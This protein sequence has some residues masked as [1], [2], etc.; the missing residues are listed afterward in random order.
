MTCRWQSRKVLSTEPWLLHASMNFATSKGG[1]DE[2]IHCLCS[3]N[4]V[5]HSKV[6]DCRMQ[7]FFK[8]LKIYQNK[9]L[10]LRQNSEQYLVWIKICATHKYRHI[11]PNQPTLDS[12]VMLLTLD[13]WAFVNRTHTVSGNKLTWIVMLNSAECFGVYQLK[14]QWRQMLHLLHLKCKFDTLGF[15]FI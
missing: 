14:S 6:W 2:A 3:D 12:T 8:K 9:P 15:C 11:R 10:K 13:S 4:Q 1:R 7:N 5:Y